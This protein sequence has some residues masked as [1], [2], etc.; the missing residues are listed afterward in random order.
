MVNDL[1]II[2]P[3]YNVQNFLY[4]CLKSIQD[5]EFKSFKCLIIDDGS[6]DKSISISQH[7]CNNDE[8]F[9]LIKC[10]H[11]SLANVQNIG[12]QNAKSKYITFCDGDDFL[13]KEGYSYVMKKML[14][15]NYDMSISDFYKVYKDKSK[16]SIKFDISQ[17]IN[18]KQLIK[19]FPVLYKKN[20]MFYDWNKIYKTDIAKKIKFKNLTVGLDTIFNYNFFNECNS[21]LFTRKCYYFYRQRMGSLVNHYDP[22][23]IN[24]RKIETSELKNLLNNW[25]VDYYNKIITQDWFKTLSLCIKN[26]YLPDSPLNNSLKKKKITDLLNICLKNINIKYLNDNEKHYLKIFKNKKKYNHYFTK[27][28]SN[29]YRYFK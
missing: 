6:N 15:H 4:K 29:N 22:N 5:Q 24:I 18:K 14:D 26:L 1:T 2:V 10:K 13:S 23:R 12:I 7:F 21:I 8:R 25:N 3:T 11:V 9:N 20:F 19:F 16:K 17:A 28:K 27:L